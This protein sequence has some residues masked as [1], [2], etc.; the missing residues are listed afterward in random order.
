MA[1][2]EQVCIDQCKF[3]LETNQLEIKGW[4]L[5][6]VTK[7]VPTIT[8][9]SENVTSDKIEW[10]PRSDVAAAHKTSANLQM[11]FEVIIKVEN[12]DEKISLDFHFSDHTQNE[13]F[14]PRENIVK[15]S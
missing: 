9:H 7:D 3:Q 1:K 2:N 11:G 6:L 13:S 15:V 10:Y 8:V 5:D 12:P 4:A 14:I